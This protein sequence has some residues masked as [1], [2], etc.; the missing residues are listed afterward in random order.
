MTAPDRTEKVTGLIAANLTSITSSAA[1]SHYPSLRIQTAN[2][3]RALLRS[4][5]E[6]TAT[7]GE[8]SSLLSD[9]SAVTQ[10][11]R[12]P[13]TALFHFRRV[14]PRI[15]HNFLLIA[16]KLVRATPPE[17]KHPLAD[18]SLLRG[19]F[20]DFCDLCTS[21]R[22]FVDTLVECSYQLCAL[23]PKYLNYKVLESLA[24]FVVVA[25][26]SLQTPIYSRELEAV[27]QEYVKM[28]SKTRKNSDFTLASHEQFPQRVDFLSTVLK[29]SY[30]RNLRGNLNS[31][32]KFC[33]DFAHVGYVSTLVVGSE[34]G[35]VY[36]GSADDVFLPRSENFAELK[37]QLL[38][39]CA[40][41]Y[42]DVFQRALQFFLGKLLDAPRDTASIRRGAVEIV[43]GLGP[44][45][46]NAGRADTGGSRWQSYR[47]SVRMQLRWS[48]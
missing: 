23:N 21:V 26:A 29:P 24:S 13:E 8:V 18:A 20:E 46:S 10:E 32:F 30:H 38:H 7:L 34:A 12:A 33:S 39:E 45:L 16:N 5:E 35:Q 42:G 48:G 40:I 9:D 15:I 3:N 44:H 31:V 27:V 17:P 22:Q 41:F 25:P 11:F 19:S 6:T 43:Q 4:V 37:L 47:D 14:G 28:N 2:L 1:L 36:M